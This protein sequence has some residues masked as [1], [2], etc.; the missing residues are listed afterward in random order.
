[1]I[2]DKASLLGLAG[3]YLLYF[4]SSFC[5]LDKKWEIAAMIFTGAPFHFDCEKMAYKLKG[6]AKYSS[7]LIR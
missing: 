3:Q 6:F 7:N 5:L 4:F 2:L 1:M